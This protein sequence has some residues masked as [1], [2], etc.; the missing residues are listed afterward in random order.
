MRVG[1]LLLTM[2]GAAAALAAVTGCG[3]DSSGE[4]GATAPASTEISIPS[5]TSPIPT[6]TAAT[7]TTTGGGKKKPAETTT[8]ATG[9]SGPC[10][11]PDL[12]QDFKYT[13]I[14]CT[15][16]VAVATAWDQNGKT[17]NTVDNPESPIGPQRTCSVEGFSCLA[18]RDIHSDAR[19]VTCTQGGQSIRFT[20][21]PA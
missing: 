15:A 20:W 19:F 12:Y 9:G 6:T 8:N 18:K 3:S 11:I 16:A 13:G 21:L 10:S 7:T 1:R 4:N 17:C 5:P 14:D 2:L